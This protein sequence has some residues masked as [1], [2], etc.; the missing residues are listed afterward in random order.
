MFSSARTELEPA[1]STTS[2]SSGSADSCTTTAY[3]CPARWIAVT[4]RPGSSRDCGSATP[5]VSTYSLRSGSQK[6]NRNEGCSS[7]RA[8]RSRAR[9]GLCDPVLSSV[10]RRFVVSLTNTRPSTRPA[11]KPNGSSNAP[12]RPIALKR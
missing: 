5:A 11:R 3:G 2:R 10:M 6:A 8:S 9:A 1:I 7:A 12:M 4:D